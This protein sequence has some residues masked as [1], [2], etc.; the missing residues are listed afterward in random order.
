MREPVLSV[1]DLSLTYSTA[2]GALQ[3][4]RDVSFDIGAGQTVA[5]V[6]ESGCG[7][8]SLAKTVYKLQKSTS[9]AIE[10]DGVPITDL[11]SAQMRPHRRKMQMVFQDPYASLNP[12]QKV[13]AILTD[14]LDVHGIGTR[15]ER[16]EK[17]AEALRRVALPTDAITKYPHQFSG[18]QRQRIG[19]ARALILEPKLL[20]CDEPV[21]ALDVSVQAQVL[22]LMARIKAEDGVAMLFIS[23]DLAVV[24]HVADRVMVMYLGEIVEDGDADLLFGQPAH[25]YT[26]TLLLAAPVPNPAIE[27]SRPRNLV[28]GDLP[29][30]FSPPAGCRFHPRCPMAVD[31]C[32]TTPPRKRE[33]AG[34]AVACHRAE[35]VVAAGLRPTTLRPTTH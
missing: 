13:E 4:F 18:G 6:G 25:P 9:G 26:R 31:I 27:R 32:R 5:L 12:R 34:R 14:P 15:A 23:H 29:S 33:V 11:G 8:S 24:R 17:V 20:I 21:S 2:N 3:A 1:R 28:I 10:L 30:P 35:E 19:L 16:R 7:K 22:N